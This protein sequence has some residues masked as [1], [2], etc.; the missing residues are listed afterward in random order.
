MPLV[1][2]DAADRRVL[3]P[4]PELHRERVAVALDLGFNSLAGRVL[5]PTPEDEAAL[6]VDGSWSG[7]VGTPAT[8]AS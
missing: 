8:R 5:L 6:N 3:R 7:R 4:A 2:H 1:V